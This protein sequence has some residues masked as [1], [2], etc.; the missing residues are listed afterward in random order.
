MIRM[1]ARFPKNWLSPVP[2]IRLT[3]CDIS[4]FSCVKMSRIQTWTEGWAEGRTSFHG[5]NVHKSLL[6]FQ[7][8]LL[9]KKPSRVLVPLCGKTLDM[10]W[11]AEEGHEVVGVEGVIQA[12]MEFFEEQELPYKESDVPGIKGAKLFENEDKKI[13]IYL[14]DFFQFSKDIAGQFD[15]I[16]DR[17]S[18]VAIDPPLR[19]QYTDVLLSVLSPGGRILIEVYEYNPEERKQKGTPHFVPEEVIQKLYGERFSIQLLATEDILEQNKF[20]KEVGLT[21]IKQKIRIMTPQ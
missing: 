15:A 7:S 16:W 6:E 21:W 9:V 1:Q 18:L 12:V 4:S 17:A 5:T 20:F 13:K 8:K 10:R 14:C 11:L 3:V 19:Q 2:F